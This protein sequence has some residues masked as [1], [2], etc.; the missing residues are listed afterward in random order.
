MDSKTIKIS[1]E[2]YQY[3]LTLASELQKTYKRPVS[4]D[5]T[6]SVM[7]DKKMN[8]NKNNLSDIA[9]KWKI[10]DKEAKEIKLDVR[11]GWNKWKI[12]SV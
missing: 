2:N 10:T 4:F 6:I 11:K 9:G 3:L 12:S 5:E 8:S 1:K 7:K